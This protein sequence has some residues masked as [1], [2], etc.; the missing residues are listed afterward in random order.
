[1]TI[2]LVIPFNNC[3][4][5]VA[6]GLRSPLVGSSDPVYD[7]QKIYRIT[8]KLAVITFGVHEVTNEVLRLIQVPYGFS[9]SFVCQLVDELL[10]HVWANLNFAEHVNLTLPEMIAGFA[11][12]GIAA[13]GPF[14]GTVLRRHESRHTFECS[15]DPRAI[16]LVANKIERARTLYL[17]QHAPLVQLA[18]ELDHG[19]V[20]QALIQAARRTIDQVA[21]Y[22]ISV[23]GK[24]THLTICS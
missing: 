4:L 2:G 18:S 9:S 3:L 1:M 8:D 22:D 15:T 7:A 16:S 23:G 24:M 13:D 19:G 17:E 12:G 5:F 6:D 11:I 20:E 10:E 14:V 21:K